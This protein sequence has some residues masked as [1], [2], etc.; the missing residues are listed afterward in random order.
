M[1]AEEWIGPGRRCWGCRVWR[2]RRR[3]G[4]R[5]AANPGTG[6]VDLELAAVEAAVIA[7]MHH[8]EFRC[9]HL[10]AEARRHLAHELRGRRAGPGRPHRR[11]G[12][13]RVL[14]RRHPAAAA[15][16]RLHRCLAFAPTDSAG[17]RAGP[18]GSR[19]GAEACTTGPSGH[20]HPSPGPPAGLQSADL[21][22]PGGPRRLGRQAVARGAGGRHRAV[23]AD[24]VRRTSKVTAWNTCGG[25]PRRS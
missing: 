13:R 12:D 8:G 25:Y 15:R 9:L 17:W 7:Y 10:L 24:R 5:L 4:W 1:S 14:R 2:P 21:T 23:R 16:A 20:Q 18:G 22:S 11:R 3:W 6:G 19:G